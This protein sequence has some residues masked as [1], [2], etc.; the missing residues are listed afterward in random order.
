M[1]SRALVLVLA[2]AGCSDSFGDAASADGRRSAANTPPTCDAGADVAVDLGNAATIDASGSSD[3]DGD[4]ITY[5]WKFSKVAT[6]STLISNDIDNRDTATTFFTPDVLGTYVAYVTCD[7]G[8]STSFDTVSVTAEDPTNNAPVADASSSDSSGIIGASVTLDGTASSD[9]DGDTLTYRWKFL[10]VPSGSTVW[11]PDIG[12]RDADVTSFTPDV[13]GTYTVWLWVDDGSGAVGD[14]WEIAVSDG[15]NTA[16]VADGSSSDTSGVPGTSVSLDASSSSDADGDSLTYRW[17]FVAVPGGSSLTSN[18]IGDRD[19]DVTSFTPDVDG[20]YWAQVR[21]SDGIVDDTD[22]VFISVTSASLNTAPVADAGSDYAMDLGDVATLDAT[23]STDADGDTLSYR[24]KIVYAPY[25]SSITSND[26]GDR[27]AASTSFTPDVEG[28]YYARV[29]VADDFDS[30]EAYVLITVSTADTGDTGTA[31]LDISQVDAG[32][33]VINEIMVNPSDC[34]DADAEY[35][36]IYNAAATPIDL[37][38]LEVTD[39]QATATVSGT[40]IVA[41]GDVAVGVRSS[42][43]RC[44]GLSYDFEWSGPVLGNT[45]DILE[46]GYGSTS[47]DDVDF[48]TWSIPVGASLELDSA[49]RDATSNDSE[50]AWCTA[51]GT[52]TGSTNDEGSPGSTTH[53]N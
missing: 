39:N 6:G 13:E 51:S 26:I 36:E 18:S 17:K 42:T 46:I 10:S 31:A 22:D 37:N 43:T 24:W 40:T 53:C 41:A 27:D 15:T 48:S 19:A 45:G 38:G 34:G 35:F 8:L 21:V 33:L 16:P 44:Y 49:S 25:N 5:R 32:W 9:A 11:S 20:T 50:S 23:G 29:L 28:P 7:D 3:P 4:T 12:D 14:S 47:F 52:F 2:L 1:S 30:D